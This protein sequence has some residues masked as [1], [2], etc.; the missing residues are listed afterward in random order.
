[1]ENMEFEQDWSDEKVDQLDEEQEGEG[2]G[3]GGLDVM[4]VEGVREERVGE[5]GAGQGEIARDGREGTG[6]E[7]EMEGVRAEVERGRREEGGGGGGV[8]R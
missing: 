8:G 1:M 2:E 6:A 7:V 3:G 5:F 4:E